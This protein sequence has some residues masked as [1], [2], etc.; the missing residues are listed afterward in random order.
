MPCSD[1]CILL[2]EFLYLSVEVVVERTIN[3]TCQRLC[4]FFTIKAGKESFDIV[5]Q[6]VDP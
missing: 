1:P 6:F 5:H 3:H 4:E 2:L